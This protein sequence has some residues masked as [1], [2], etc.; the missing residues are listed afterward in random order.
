M[1]RHC[2][3]YSSVATW[4]CPVHPWAPL[5]KKVTLAHWSPVKCFVM[6]WC[7][8]S[9]PV[10]TVTP[11]GAYTPNTSCIPIIVTAENYAHTS[12]APVQISK[13]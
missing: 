3:D 4:S 6:G 12:P 2:P 8:C 5:N 7:P 13:S 9:G 10:I 11:D 1:S